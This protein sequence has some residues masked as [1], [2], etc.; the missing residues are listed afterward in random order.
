MAIS[1]ERIKQDILKI[2]A[3]SKLTNNKVRIKETLGNPTNVIVLELDYPTAPSS[4]YPNEVQNKTSLKIELLSRYPFQEPSATI[5]TPIFHPNVYASG[6]V[7]LGT[8]WL[9]TQGLDLLI[10]RII[11][12]I[13]FDPLILNEASPANGKAL[14][15]YKQASTQYPSSFPTDRLITSKARE[16]KMVWSELSG[17]E[18]KII[19]NCPN[20]YGSSRVP[21]GKNLNITCPKCRTTFRAQT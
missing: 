10:K 18:D 5:T 13:T 12:I 4:H 15:W 2:E 8:K 1:N 3:L 14:S 17:A 19:V 16:K 11:Q 7:C 21:K 20:C 9:P 6:K